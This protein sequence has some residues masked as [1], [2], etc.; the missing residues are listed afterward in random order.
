MQQA[1]RNIVLAE[2]RLYRSMGFVGIEGL[3]KRK[4]F[5]T[6]IGD[7]PFQFGNLINLTL[8]ACSLAFGGR[9]RLL[10]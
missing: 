4:D 10:A 2:N 6:L 1:D 8:P 7:R 3:A 9:H 5:P